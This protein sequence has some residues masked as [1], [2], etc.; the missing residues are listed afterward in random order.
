MRQGL[1][2]NK[3]SQYRDSK[4]PQS[5]RE[6]YHNMSVMNQEGDKVVLPRQDP[7][8]FWNLL[9]Q[10]YIKRDDSK[11][12]DLAAWVLREQAGWSY[13]RIG[14]A[15]GCDRG[16]IYRILSQLRSEMKNTFREPP[17]WPNNHP[18]KEQPE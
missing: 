6:K 7:P 10:N 4:S 3:L 12:R 15:L 14:I 16:H 18:D 17:D 1:L 11:W 5:T 13:E 8:E 2:R 9:E